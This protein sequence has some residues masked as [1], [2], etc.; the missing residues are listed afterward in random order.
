MTGTS[1]EDP[2]LKSCMKEFKVYARK[3]AMI[4]NI[5]SKAYNVDH[6]SLIFLMNK[7]N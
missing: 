6:T 5:D 3:V 4:D 7:H 1:E 2:A